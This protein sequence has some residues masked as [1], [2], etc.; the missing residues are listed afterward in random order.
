MF[1][2]KNKDMKNPK[3]LNDVVKEALEN[4]VNVLLEI[5][6]EYYDVKKSFNYEG[7]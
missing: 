6:G 1:F 3:P 4:D 2:V 5:N 7:K